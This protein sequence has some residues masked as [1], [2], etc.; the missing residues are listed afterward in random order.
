MLGARDSGGAEFL[1]TARE[2]IAHPL[3]LTE[4]QQTGTA[5][6]HL[7]VRL[8]YGGDVGEGACHDARK[9]ALEPRD[10]FLQRSPGSALGN[11]SAGLLADQ[12]RMRSEILVSI[13]HPRDFDGPSID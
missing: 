3:E 7:D 13:E 5:I 9:L 12:D 1:R 10:L 6:R 2:A 4:V 11:G 8:A